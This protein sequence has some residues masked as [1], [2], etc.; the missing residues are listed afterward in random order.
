MGSA[1]RPCAWASLLWGCLSV[2]LAQQVTVKHEV[3]GYLGKRVVLPCNIAVTGPEMKVS[4]VTWVKEVGGR[5]QNVAVHHPTHGQSYPMEKNSRRIR[6]AVNSLTDATLVIEHLLMSD[7]GTYS[8]EFATYPNGNEL[9][10]TNLIVLAKP[11]S[12][13]EAMEVK[14]SN[15]EQPV[16]VCTSANGKPPARVTW[17]SKLNGNSSIKQ[18]NNSDGTVTVINRYNLIPTKEAN[19]QQIICLVEH[20][21]LPQT[22]SFPV[23]L[24]ILYAPEVAIDGYDGNWY[25]TRNDA[26][27]VCSARGNP[28]PID[29]SWTTSNGPLPK[30]VEVQGQR[31]FVKKVDYSVNTTFICQATNRVG[32]VSTQQIILVRDQPVKSQSRN[33]GALAGGIVGG[34]LALAVLGIIVFFILRRRHP[35]ASKGSFDPK[36]RAFGN[37]TAQ[38]Q[39][40]DFTELDRPLKPAT[41]RKPEEDEDE[42]DYREEEREERRHPPYGYA[43]RHREDEEE[44]FDQ[45]GPIL[46]FSPDPHGYDYDDMESQ[47]DGSIISKTAV[48][49]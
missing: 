17:Q 47:H 31:L 2:V 5:R 36:T 12:S 1:R 21:A 14:S 20:V 33:V 26:T 38:P 22:E 25:L 43:P 48:Y 49:V 40:H 6:F 30:S 45:L 9:N 13:A 7:E 37:G 15:V 35:R 39:T 8:C 28:T 16:A 4:Q 23:Q 34:I 44:R 41:G 32:Q 3:T 27:L 10:T 18:I 29:F 11:T 46:R 19:E 42:D 24:S